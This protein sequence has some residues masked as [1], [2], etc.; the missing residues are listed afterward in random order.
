MIKKLFF[1]I[2]ATK[3][4]HKMHIKLKESKIVGNKQWKNAVLQFV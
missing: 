4:L 3:L 1:V 2:E